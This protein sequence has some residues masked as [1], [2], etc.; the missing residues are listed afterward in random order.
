MKTTVRKFRP[1]AP[2]SHRI[3]VQHKD[4]GS[5]YATRATRATR[6]HPAGKPWFSCGRYYSTALRAVKGFIRAFHAPEHPAETYA[7]RTAEITYRSGLARIC[8]E[9]E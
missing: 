4:A 1:A 8:G 7:A 3:H 9:T 2:Y 6:D 5:I